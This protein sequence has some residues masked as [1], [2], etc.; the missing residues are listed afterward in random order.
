M[1][2]NIRIAKELVR[3]AKNLT[4]L[5]EEGDGSGFQYLIDR[6]NFDQDQLD[7]AEKAGKKYIL[8]HQVHGFWRI[9]ACKD[10][11][12]N[13]IQV[14]KGDFGGFVESEKNLSHEGKCWIFNEAKVIDNAKVC[15]DATVIQYAYVMQNAII[16]DS[17]RI[18]DQVSVSDNATIYENAQIS[19]NA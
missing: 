11:N 5:D 17:A 18:E 2:K 19:G 10:F 14:K 16:K 9:Q 6:D 1:N 15:D 3:I 8:H 7:M 13:F 12:T 4:A